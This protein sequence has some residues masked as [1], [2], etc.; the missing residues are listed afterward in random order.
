YFYE[1]QWQ[2]K[3]LRRR[4]E[5][6]ANLANLVIGA[7]E[8]AEQLRPWSIKAIEKFG[9]KHY[10]QIEPEVDAVCALYVVEALR[11]LGVDLRERRQVRPQ[12]ENLN[13]QPRH[14]RLL[15][16][17]IE[18]LCEDGILR[19]AGDRLAVDQL[20]QT[21]AARSKWQALITAHPA[22]HAELSL[23]GR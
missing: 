10:R 11:E 3:Q 5:A 6:S 17:M 23:L 1:I 19:R 2:P 4:G 20:P 12:I 9:L 18:V 16:R 15:N 13:V 21:G 7:A 22:Y 14:R 8:L